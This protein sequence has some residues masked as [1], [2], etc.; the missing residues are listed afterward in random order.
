MREEHRSLRPLH[1][2]LLPGPFARRGGLA[3][4]QGSP[5]THSERPVVCGKA[6]EARESHARCGRLTSHSSLL[7]THS[8]PQPHTA[9]F[10]RFS[11]ARYTAPLTVLNRAE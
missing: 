2:T 3:W 6:L 9:A 1:H 8:S 7:A 5:A 11:A 10:S 4:G